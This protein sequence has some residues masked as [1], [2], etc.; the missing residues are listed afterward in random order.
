VSRRA[1]SPKALHPP[2]GRYSQGVLVEG[3]S[4]LLLLS[5][6]LGIRPDGTIPP[7][8][9][10]QTAVILDGIDACLREGGLARSDVLRLST[11][12]TEPD[13]RLPYM[14]LRD[15]WVADPPPASTLIVVKALARPAFKIEIEA[16]AGR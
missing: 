13:Y 7:G 6:L 9:E 3:S 12:I 5:G 2:F 14:R 1:L 10:E 4:R 8:V 16:I 11:F 15:I